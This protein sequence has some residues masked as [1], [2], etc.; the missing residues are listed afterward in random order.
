MIDILQKTDNNLHPLFR[1]IA[2]EKHYVDIENIL[3][4]EI[5][6][7]NAHDACTE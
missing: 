5:E 7:T 2:V 3:L 6:N 1:D 4:N